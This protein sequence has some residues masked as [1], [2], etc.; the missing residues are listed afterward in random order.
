MIIKEGRD[1]TKAILALISLPELRNNICR[2]LTRVR[3]LY[4]YTSLSFVCSYLFLREITEMQCRM[5]ILP[6]DEFGAISADF[7]V[8]Y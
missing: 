7:G 2:T 8:F 1:K 4:F 3:C 5:I 6:S